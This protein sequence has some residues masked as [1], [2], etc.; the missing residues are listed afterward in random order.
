MYAYRDQHKEYRRRHDL[1]WPELHIGNT[2]SRYKFLMGARGHFDC[3]ANTTL[4]DIHP[5]FVSLRLLNCSGDIG[6]KESY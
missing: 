2:N 1:I 6:K 5:R 4:C 3:R